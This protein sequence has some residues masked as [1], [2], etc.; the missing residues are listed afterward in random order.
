MSDADS[1][2][3]RPRAIHRMSFDEDVL[4]LAAIAAGVHRQRA[5]DRAG[6]AA[7]EFEA[8][9]AGIGRGARDRGIER[10][11][12]RLEPRLADRLDACRRRTA[13]GSRRPEFRR[14]GSA[15]SSRRRSR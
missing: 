11:S 4:D 9:D 14:R 12:A 10:G 1:V 7:Q 13:A 3:T 15:D 6:N 5:A 8:V 2:T